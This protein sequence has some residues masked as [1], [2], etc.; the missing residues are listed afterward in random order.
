M[1][2]GLK[3][4][5]ALWSPQSGVAGMGQEEGAGGQKFVPDSPLLLSPWLQGDFLYKKT[6]VGRAVQK[7]LLETIP[8]VRFARHPPLRTGGSDRASGFSRGMQL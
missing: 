8:P 3:E 5:L 7:S 2:V 6:L 4:L 1:M